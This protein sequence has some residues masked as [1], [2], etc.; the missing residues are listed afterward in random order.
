[1]IF[2]FAARAFDILG[3]N[4]LFKA[5][6]RVGT[7]SNHRN[8]EPRIHTHT[9][10]HTYTHTYIHTYIHTLHTSGGCLGVSPA[11][12]VSSGSAAELHGATLGLGRRPARPLR[13]C[14]LYCRSSASLGAH[15][16]RLATPGSN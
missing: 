10:I 2:F 12:A 8:F 16:L 7:V 6:I 1:M 9:Y 13:S 5:W 15:P 4:M 3:A 11:A 14:A